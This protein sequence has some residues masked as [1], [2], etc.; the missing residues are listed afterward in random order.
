MTCAPPIAVNSH[1]IFTTMLGTVYVI[2]ASVKQFDAKAVVGV[3]DL[4]HA[5]KT[6]TLGNPAASGGRLFFRTLK[7]VVCIEN[8]EGK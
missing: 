5:G 4:G 2:D 8:A 7:E 1:V 6:W 3:N